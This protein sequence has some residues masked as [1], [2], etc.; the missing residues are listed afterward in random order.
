MEIRLKKIDDLLLKVH[1]N[2]QDGLKKS[3]IRLIKNNLLLLHSI[4]M[5]IK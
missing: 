5:E 3:N 4:I 1:K 2:I